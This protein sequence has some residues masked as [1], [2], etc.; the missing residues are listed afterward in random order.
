MFEVFEKLK[1]QKLTVETW[2]IL[3]SSTKSLQFSFSHFLTF[4]SSEIREFR[5][6]QDRIV[7]LYLF[8]DGSSFIIPNR[9][10][11][12]RALPRVIHSLTLQGRT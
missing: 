2:H 3:V 6:K 12:L 11:L 10:P 4:S 5:P 8:A 1:D 9:V 7:I